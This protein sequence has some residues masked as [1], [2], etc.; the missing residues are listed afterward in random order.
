M[1]KG[2][3]HS[4]EA[5]ERIGLAGVGRFVSDATRVKLSLSGKGKRR[6]PEACARMGAARRG[7][8]LSPNHRA[9]LRAAKLGKKRGPMSDTTKAKISAAT[10]GHPGYM[11]GQRHT[12][13]AKARMS[14]AQ[15]G[16]VVTAESRIRI[17]EAVKKAWAN[18]PRYRISV[19]DGVRQRWNDPGY[20]ASIVDANTGK[21]LTENAKRHLGEMSRLRWQDPSFKERT[22]R[23]SRKASSVKPTAPERE[24]R[25]ILDKHFPGEWRYTGNGE[26]IVGGKNPD[27][28]DVQN[29]RVIEVFGDD[30]HSEAVTGKLPTQEE[31][32]RIV[33]FVEHGMSCLVVWEHEVGDEAAVLGKVRAMELSVG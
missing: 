1:R 25:D 24:M 20:R 16:K 6:S 5:R 9:K 10:T 19:S 29:Q 12:V 31:S 15:R 22:L 33:H 26:V 17:S 32:D 14:I 11:A 4:A 3:H 8:P 7:F 18:D 30:W 21:R 23:A 27:F 2:S 13:E 28:V